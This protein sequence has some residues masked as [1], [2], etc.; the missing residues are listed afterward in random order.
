MQDIRKQKSTCSTIEE[1]NGCC[2]SPGRG[3]EVDDDAGPQARAASVLLGKQNTLPG[4]N[5]G[6]LEMLHTGFWQL[7]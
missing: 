7:Q 6:S 1:V 5:L 3:A 4:P 2:L